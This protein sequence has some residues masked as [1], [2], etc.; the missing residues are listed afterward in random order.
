MSDMKSATGQGAVERASMAIRSSARDRRLGE[1]LRGLRRGYN[2]SV[3]PVREAIGDS[4]SQEQ[5]SASRHE[6]RT[7]VIPRCR[8]RPEPLSADDIR[9]PSSRT[10]KCIASNLPLPEALPTKI[11][12]ECIILAGVPRA[13]VT[14]SFRRRTKWKIASQ[15]GRG[16]RCRRAVRQINHFEQGK[17][18]SARPVEPDQTL[19]AEEN[20]VRL[21][22]IGNVT[23]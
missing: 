11:Y 7:G 13:C 6:A 19:T 18:Y 20:P 3:G 12:E 14:P 23:Y 2:R 5:L 8:E 10:R 21:A 1:D 4:W 17:S 15:V 16:H 9:T 22:W